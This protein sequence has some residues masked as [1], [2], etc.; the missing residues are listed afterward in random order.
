MQNVTVSASYL[1]KQKNFKS[2]VKEIQT[3]LKSKEYAKEGQSFNDYVK[4]K[5]NISQAQ[6]YRYLLCAKVLDQLEEFEIQPSYERVCNALFHTV[7][8]P[9]QMK[10]LWSVILQKAGTVPESINSTHIKKIWKEIC[11]NEKYSHLCQSEENIAKKIENSLNKFS[12][13]KKHKQLKQMAAQQQINSSSVLPYSYIPSPVLSE[14]SLTSNQTENPLYSSMSSMN[15]L[16]IPLT[17]EYTNDCSSILYNSLESIALP[18]TPSTET[19]Y[20]MIQ[21]TE[22]QYQPQQI[23]YYY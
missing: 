15:S 20:Y 14:S 1:E 9:A 10:I 2:L 22:I 7:K 18:T 4:M 5:W 8:T 13:E 16:N 12:N 6:A 21:P 17:P 11:M 3:S 23:I 19:L